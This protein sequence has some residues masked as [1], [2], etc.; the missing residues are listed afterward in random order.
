MLPNSFASAW[1]VKRA[2]RRGSMGLC[3]RHANAAA[4][5]RGS[6]AGGQHA[7]GRLLSAPDARAR[8][9]QRSAGTGRYGSRSRAFGR[10]LDFSSSGDGMSRRRSSSLRRVRRMELP[11]GGC[12]ATSPTW[13]RCWCGRAAP[14]ACWSAAVRTARPRGRLS[15]ISTA[16]CASQ[17]IDV[18]GETTLEMLA[19]LLGIA[20]ACVSND[21]GAMH[22]AA[23]VGT[24]VVALFGPTNE[25]ETSPLTRQGRQSAV[26]THRV[27]CRPCM[28]RECPIDHRCMK[29]ITPE[30]VF[31]TL[32]RLTSAYAPSGVP[33]S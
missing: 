16:L 14:R 12:R 9:R 31:D 25:Y 7:P 30:R 27:W 19:G 1:L 10:S 6:S 15:A 33:G 20:Q 17:V 29:G 13:H 5:A 26:L 2:R 8:H 4:V 28:L 32:T 21:S 11:S 18:T 3:V 22:L 24:P 23:A